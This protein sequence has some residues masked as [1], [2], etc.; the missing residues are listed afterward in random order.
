M[1]HLQPQ[2]GADELL[3]KTFDVGVEAGYDW[4]DEHRTASATEIEIRHAVL[5][6]PS[7]MFRSSFYF[8]HAD[9]GESMPASER[10]VYYASSEWAKEQQDKLKDEI[11][12][13]DYPVL[14]GYKNVKD[15]ASEVKVQ[16]LKQIDLEFPK[17][18]I[19]TMRDADNAVR[20]K[21]GI[22]RVTLCMW[23]ASWGS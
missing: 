16:L 12:G 22:F 6:D 10:S 18:D 13:L 23:L 7:Y 21:R 15:L 3:N 17:S 4:V 9:Y 1:F 19:V 8:R 11:R 14:E 20:R 5:N 2:V